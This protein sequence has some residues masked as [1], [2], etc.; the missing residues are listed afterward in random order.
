MKKIFNTLSIL[1]LLQGAVY[2]Q[3]PAHRTTATKIADVLAQQPAEEAAKFLSAM[4]ELEGF[5]AD[6]AAALLS[7]L[8]PQGAN[9]APIEY[10]SNSYALYVMQSGK[11]ELR[12]TYIQ[13]L[14]QALDKLEDADNK[15]YVL[16]LLKFCAKDE[17]VA[18]VSG[19]LSDE[20]LAEKA[21]RVLSGIHSENAAKALNEGLRQASSE[22][23]ATAIVGA[24]GELGAQG[25]EDRILELLQ[26]YSSD[27]FGR[28]ALTTL[29]KTG[30]LKSYD[31]FANKAKTVNY[32]LDNSSTAA[33]ALNY[34]E[35]L[36]AIGHKKEAIRLVSGFY[37]EATDTQAIGARVGALELLAKLDPTKKQKKE[38]LKLALGT[39]ANLRNVALDLLKERASTSDVKKLTSSLKKVSPE[40]QEDILQFLADNNMVAAAPAVEKSYASLKEPVARIA[41]I[42]ALSTLSNGNNTAFLLAQLPTANSDEQEAIKT[43][44]LSSKGTDVVSQINGALGTADV[45]TQLVLLDVLSQ[46]SNTESSQAVFELIG[47]TADAKVRSAAYKA[48]PTVVND[49]DFEKIIDVLGKAEDDHIKYVQ[50]AA[51]GA[52]LYANDRDAKVQRLTAN[53]SKSAAPSAAKYFP[54]FAGEGGSVSLKAVENYLSSS[55]VSRQD[56]IQ[57]LA[58]WS[59]TSSLKTLTQ[60]L[61]TEKDAKS[62]NTV[63]GGFIKQV[64]ASDLKDEQKTLLLR[65]AFELAKTDT[66]RK[67]ALSSLKATG[68]YQALAFASTLLDDEQLKSVA[69]DVVMNVAMDNTSFV[70]PDVRT[71][72]E[73]AKNNLSGSESSYLS[74]A[75]T[76]HL[77]EMP[78]GEGYVSLFNGKDLAGWKGLVENPIK[79]ANMSA[80][81]LAEKQVVADKEMRDS[82]SAVDGDLVFGGQGKNIATIKQYGDFE[83]LVDWKLDKNGKEPDA[84]VYLRGTPQVQIWDISRTNVGAEVG[85]GGLYNNKVHESKPLKVADNPLGDWNTFKIRMVDDKVW[86]WLNGELVVDGTTLE[87]FWDRKQSIFPFE[88]IELQ[89]HGSKVWYRN[90]FV[91]ELPRK[92]IFSLSDQE[93]KEGFEMLFDGASL[94]KWTSTPAYEINEE[95]VIRANPNAKFGKNMYTKEEYGDFVYR[96]EFK[97]TPGANNGIGIRAPLEGDA[98]YLGYEIQVLDDDAEVY[99]KL[100]PYQYHGSVYG[101]IPA[102]RG[103]LKPMGEWNEEEIRIQGS[104]IKVTLNGQVIVDGDIQEASKNGTLDKKNHPGLN[105]AS[106]HIGFLGHGSEVFYRNIRIK[107]L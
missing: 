10:A 73:R 2:A 52:L 68:T 99:K 49:N 31:Y 45:G 58:S 17:A 30:T 97:L 69:T 65:E 44:L 77:A 92:Q 105:K 3:Q 26:V 6:D 39:D 101:I 25:A 43:I 9:N 72:L 85:S 75:I 23:V 8:K 35:H 74:E 106:G 16:E 86:V 37:G 67:S 34:A 29:S 55:N 15:G 4:K 14:L 11:E 38:L 27:N 79:R 21:A 60:L 36:A 107:K 71:W 80:K 64:N 91:K 28:V 51:V 82:W 53:I 7:G 78:S 61:R 46:R 98:A 102:K 42:K 89:A 70:G 96:F 100:A 48:L 104:K 40:V 84:G 50:Q 19:Y 22:K 83:M 20:Y 32:K 63:F 12:A 87:N 81:E 93:K 54:V 1:F 59:N 24:I 33:L 103:A 76:R 5:T 57:A 13:G 41:A 18:A 62:F 88:Q 90:I 94:D 95:G 66:Q 56:A 47:K